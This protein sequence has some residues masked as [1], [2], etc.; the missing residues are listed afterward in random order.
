MSFDL[1]HIT[2]KQVFAKYLNFYNLNYWKLL[3]QKQK[4]WRCPEKT[5]PN[6]NNYM[7]GFRSKNK[8]KHLHCRYGWISLFLSTQNKEERNSSIHSKAK[9]CTLKSY[10]IRYPFKFHTLKRQ[11][12]DLLYFL[13]SHRPSQLCMSNQNIFLAICILKICCKYVSYIL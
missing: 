3:L 6:N 12:I 5:L 8:W 4:R 9:M 1:L 13:I 2:Y 10:F 11:G 7:V